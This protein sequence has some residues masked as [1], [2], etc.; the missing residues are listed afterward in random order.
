[1]LSVFLR[2]ITHLSL[3][4][5][6]NSFT[7]IHLP[8]DG[9]LTPDLQLFVDLIEPEGRFS[10]LK[11]LRVES[12]FNIEGFRGHHLLEELPNLE[13]L[14]IRSRY[15]KN[16]KMLVAECGLTKD[17]ENP[18]CPNLK[19]LICN[20]K[21]DL[22]EKQAIFKQWEKT[23]KNC[24]NLERVIF[25][26]PSVLRDEKERLDIS[27]YRRKEG[28]EPHQASDLQKEPE[29]IEEIMLQ[30][31]S[32]LII[33]FEQQG[34]EVIIDSKKNL[35]RERESYRPSLSDPSLNSLLGDLTSERE[36]CEGDLY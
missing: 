23:L 17:S 12:K 19:T 20:P 8:Q 21:F 33:F 25:E 24:P 1:M 7:Y 15:P 34:I 4:P 31:R 27:P 32:N 28:D 2:G 22:L 18:V 11:E 29:S 9:P 5:L 16:M 10:Q 3:A 6:I 26:Y 13:Y 30:M 35:K 14:V 36:C